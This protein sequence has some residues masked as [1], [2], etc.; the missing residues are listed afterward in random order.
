MPPIDMRRFGGFT[1]RRAETVIVCVSIE[2]SNVMSIGTLTVTVSFG[3]SYGHSVRLVA[4][5]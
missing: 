4:S 2:Y 5:A 3:A 1:S